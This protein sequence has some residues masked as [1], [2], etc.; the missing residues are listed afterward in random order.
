[1]LQ[2]TIGRW[3][4]VVFVVRALVDVP[5]VL[6]L[7]VILFASLAS[8]ATIYMMIIVSSVLQIVKCAWM[9]QPV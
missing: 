5:R 1:M 3:L 4:V 6:N 7:A 9:D 8:I 2:G